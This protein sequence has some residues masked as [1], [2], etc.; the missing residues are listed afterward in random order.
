MWKFIGIVQLFVFLTGTSVFAWNKMPYDGHDLSREGDNW[1]HYEQGMRMV[2]AR[3]WEQADNE[4]RYY[5]DHG[6]MHRRMW[7]I[8]YYG[9]AVMSQK[10]GETNQALEYYKLAIVEDKHP[11][12][13]VADKVYQ[14]LGAIYLKRKE[15]KSAIENYLKAIGKDPK[16]GLSHYYLGMAYL[17]S[18]DLVNA[19]KEDL[20]AK[21][22][23]VNFTA[24]AEGISE[25]KNPS[26]T[27]PSDDGEQ[28]AKAKNKKKKATK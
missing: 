21:K 5:L 24:L 7:G 18:G 2:D 25:A 14:N 9:F 16:S 8:A 3:N 10:K 19:E 26:L 23:G 28:P 4:F 1:Y 12:V 27:K 11:T 6:A 17:K 15:Y 22:L 20:E 13:S